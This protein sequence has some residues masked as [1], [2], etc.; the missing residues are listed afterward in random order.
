MIAVSGFRV[1][2][3]VSSLSPASRS[4]VG[5]FLVVIHPPTKTGSREDDSGNLLGHMKWPLLSS[6]DFSWIPPVG[7]GLLLPYSLPGPPVYS[8]K[9]LLWSLA[10]SGGF[11]QYESWKNYIQYSVINYNGNEYEKDCVCECVCVCV[12]ES[13]CCTAETNTTCKSTVFQ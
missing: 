10:W 3:L 9:C 6:L 8:F 7:G 11:S 2:G 12:T 5:S 1:M 4:D 13:L